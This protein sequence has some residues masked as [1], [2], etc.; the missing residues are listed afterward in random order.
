MAISAMAA[1]AVVLVILSF[2]ETPPSEE[3]LSD[4]ALDAVSDLEAALD[5]GD[6]A[7]VENLLAPEWVVLDLPG[8]GQRI[9][10]GREASGAIQFYVETVDIDVAGCEVEPATEPITHLVECEF[11]VGGDL[12]VALGYESAAGVKVGVDGDEIVSLFQ[13]SDKDVAPGGDYCIWAEVERPDD[14]IGAFDLKCLPTG[15]ASVHQRL[16]AEFVKAGRPE[17]SA[18]ELESR[19]SVGLVAAMEA[20][21]HDPKELATI[22]L[23]DWP[24]VRYPGLMPGRLRPPFPSVSEYLAWSDVAYEVELGS[25]E[26]ATRMRNGGFEIECPEAWWSGALV[27]NL[28]L[29]P[30]SQPI[31]FYVDDARITGV[32]G[33]TS[34][35][36][37]TAVVGLCKWARANR[38]DRAAIAFRADCAPNYTPDGATEIVA[39]AEDYTRQS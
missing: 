39:L 13:E 5:D 33:N 15:D 35:T 14:A 31:G 26:V 9:L 16:A 34:P 25:C 17:P 21:Q 10:P 37:E 23:E 2:N 22:F 20:F 24:L 3:R 4:Q 27:A 36:L 7:A 19:G 30:I 6:V 11:S 1:L 38:V 18:E 29:D 12:A 8:S 28:G 32:S